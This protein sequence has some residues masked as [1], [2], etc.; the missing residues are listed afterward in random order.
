MKEESAMNKFDTQLTTKENC[1]GAINSK[2]EIYEI[3]E[4]QLI[5]QV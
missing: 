5:P 4:I 3:K 1:S 2:D